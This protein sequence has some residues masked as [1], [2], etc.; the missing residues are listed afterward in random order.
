MKKL[1]FILGLSL[2]TTGVFATNKTED[3]TENKELKKE[4]E[5]TRVCCTATLHYNGVP[6]DSATACADDIPTACKR[7]NAAVLAKN[8]DA[9][10]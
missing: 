6:V 9:Q 8:P 1:I 4:N 3:K 10:L 2:M 7:A 5:D